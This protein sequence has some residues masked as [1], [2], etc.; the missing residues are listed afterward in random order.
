MRPAVLTVDANPDALGKGRPFGS[1]L[2]LTF[3]NNP[4]T[5]EESADTVVIKID[6]ISMADSGII[7]FISRNPID[8]DIGSFRLNFLVLC[9]S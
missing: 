2:R 3:F 7:F 1:E 9:E 6:A 8:I 5:G 4:T